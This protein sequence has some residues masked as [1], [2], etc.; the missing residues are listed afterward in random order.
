MK[1]T[2]DVELQFRERPVPGFHTLV[3]GSAVVDRLL[4]GGEILTLEDGLTLEVFH[5]NVS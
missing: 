4:T 3:G 1:V 2:E 5:T